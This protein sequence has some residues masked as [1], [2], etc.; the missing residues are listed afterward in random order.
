[1]N[2]PT[3]EGFDTMNRFMVTQRHDGTLMLM[4]IGGMRPFTKNDALS[5]VA[6]LIVMGELDP[7]DVEAC[8][9]A[10]RNAT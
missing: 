5:L 2:K 6:W 3:P 10:V 4:T 8:A 1:M 9:E 7:A